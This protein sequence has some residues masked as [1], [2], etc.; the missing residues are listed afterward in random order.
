MRLIG[1]ES[2]HPSPLLPPQPVNGS[3]HVL[4]LASE[5][6]IPSLERTLFG[7]RPLFSNPHLQ[8]EILRYSLNFKINRKFC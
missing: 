1:N 5:P 7:F 3:R 6:C 2:H 4:R 8:L